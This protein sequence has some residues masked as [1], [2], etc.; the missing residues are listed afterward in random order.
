MGISFAAAASQGCALAL[1]DLHDLRP[2]EARY[3]PMH[4]HRLVDQ[5]NAPCIQPSQA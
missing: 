5:E 1:S 2:D 4:D 3:G